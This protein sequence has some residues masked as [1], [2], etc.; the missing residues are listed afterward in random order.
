MFY[1]KKDMDSLYFS[2]EKHCAKYILP[3]FYNSWRKF[4]CMK[5]YFVNIHANLLQEIWSGGSSYYNVLDLKSP[6]IIFF[7]S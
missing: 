5:T 6:A 4:G 3:P 7:F 1:V 2:I